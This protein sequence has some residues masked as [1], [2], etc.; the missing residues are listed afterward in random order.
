LTPFDHKN[1]TEIAWSGEI[2]LDV[3]WAH[4]IAP[5]AKIVLALSPS[6]ADA[7]IVATER[8]VINHNIGDV[9]SMSYGEAEQCMDP[10]LQQAQ[11]LAFDDANAHGVS[12][13]SGAGD[14]GAAQYACKGSGFV[15][16]VSIPASDPDVTAVGGTQLTADINTGAY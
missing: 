2:A 3:E 5:G 14:Q 7:D 1:S 15:K 12:L 8:Y 10:E 9:I 4:A 6:D 13:F 16:A 11:H